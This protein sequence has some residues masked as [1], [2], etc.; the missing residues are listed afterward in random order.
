MIKTRIKAEI[1]DSLDDGYFN[2]HD[3][4]IQ[5]R[6]LGNITLIQINYEYDEEYY[7]QFNIP[8]KKE[9]FSLPLDENTNKSYFDFKIWGEKVPGE[10]VFRESFIIPGEGSIYQ[11]ISEWLENLWEE[12]TSKPTERFA[13]S[14][15]DEI[16]RLK[17]MANAFPD[18]YFTKEEGEDLEKRLDKME[19]DFTKRIKELEKDKKVAEEQIKNFQEQIEVLK[20]TIPALKKRGWFKS[21]ITKT[22]TWFSDPKNQK[23]MTA[24]RDLVNTMLPENTG[25]L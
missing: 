1:E 23:L 17:Q 25:H 16:E 14:Q 18:E 22:M 6:N 8:D 21:F 4:L 2:K 10:V 13:K 15:K 5:T 3:F 24:G 11:T 7:I 9:N 19:K 12:L 20:E